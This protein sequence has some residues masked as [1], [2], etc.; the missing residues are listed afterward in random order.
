MVE[1]NDLKWKLFKRTYKLHVDPL[2]EYCKISPWIPYFSTI[3]RTE[4]T[5]AC[6]RMVEPHDL[7]W[8]HFQRFICGS[9]F[10]TIYHHWLMEYC[11]TIYLRL[12]TNPSTSTG[13]RK[14]RSIENSSKPD[15]DHWVII[16]ARIQICLAQ[17][18]PV[19]V[20]HLIIIGLGAS[21]QTVSWLFIW[22]VVWL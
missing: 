10:W 3:Y 14:K 18:W 19:H 16:T 17:E 22:T 15:P 5:V 8:L 12:L 13:K 9:P 21:V 20:P 1:S 4:S 7:K 2:F 11:S 6:K